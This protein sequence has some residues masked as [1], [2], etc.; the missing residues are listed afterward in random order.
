MLKVTVT[1][2]R[3]F[4]KHG[5]YAQERELGVQLVADIIAHVDLE[6]CGSDRIQDTVDYIEL[7]DMLEAVSEGHSYR[8]LEAL[9]WRFAQACLK[10]W[11]VIQRLTV[12][13]RKPAPAAAV[14]LDS[15]GIEVTVTRDA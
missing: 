14:A 5:V 15:V 13:I 4:G 1:G 8:T 9:G 3:F 11:P 2:Y 12:K 6:V 10:E 7:A